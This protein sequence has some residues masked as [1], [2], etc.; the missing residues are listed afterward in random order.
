MELLYQSLTVQLVPQPRQMPLPP[1]DRAKLQEIFAEVTEKYDYQSFS[2]TPNNRGALFQ[3]APDDSIELRPAQLQINAKLSGPEPLTAEAAEDKV[4]KI[5]ELACERLEIPGFLQAAIQIV[6]LVTL[7]EDNPDAKAFV[8]DHLMQAST[9]PAG[10]GSDY[11][12]AGVRFR[13][14]KEDGSGEDSLAIEPFVQDGSFLYVDYQRARVAMQ[15]PIELDLVSTL[16]GEGFGFL[17]G[18]TK[19]L[20]SPE[21]RQS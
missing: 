21:G 9:N 3:N 7:P 17:S 10:L 5:L 2:F 16:I 19:E 12:G 4:M 20:L 14:I 15:G 6:T 8:M 18:P 1:F 11:F 13:S